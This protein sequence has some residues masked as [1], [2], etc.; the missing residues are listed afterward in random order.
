MCLL[1]KKEP[2]IQKSNVIF[3]VVYQ[4]D[5]WQER[6]GILQQSNWGELN[7]GTIYKGELKV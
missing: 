1:Y 3:K 6:D 4:S 7:E 5:F 2:D